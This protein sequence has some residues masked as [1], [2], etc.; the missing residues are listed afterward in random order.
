[1]L[2]LQ[3]PNPISLDFSKRPEKTGNNHFVCWSLW[4]VLWCWPCTLLSSPRWL[5]S[6]YR[7]MH[8]L[9]L[10]ADKKW[11]TAY[12]T[13]KPDSLSSFCISSR[14][15]NSWPYMSWMPNFIDMHNIWN[16]RPHNHLK[17][18][19]KQTKSWIRNYFTTLA[20]INLRMCSI[21]SEALHWR[22]SRASGT[23]WTKQT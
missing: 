8:Q 4:E 16:S 15:L 10:S 17:G 1:M 12:P 2:V 9:F 21:R 6:L 3:K 19:H 14:S 20:N 7:N 22:V 11:T 13:K 23:I 5:Y 18:H